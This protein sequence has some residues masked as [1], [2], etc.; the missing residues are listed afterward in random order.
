VLIVIVLVLVLVLEKRVRGRHTD[1]TYGTHGT[2]EM[3]LI[4]LVF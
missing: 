4:E 3:A 2:I 1:G